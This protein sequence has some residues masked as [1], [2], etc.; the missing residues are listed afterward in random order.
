MALYKLTKGTLSRIRT[1]KKGIDELL[2]NGYT[3]DG[4]VNKK[5]EVVNANPFADKEPKK[6]KEH[7]KEDGDNK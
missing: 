1:D 3:L 2:K 4:E 5:Y 7:K 6:C